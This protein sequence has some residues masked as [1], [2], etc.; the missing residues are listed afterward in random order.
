MKT[1]CVN[2]QRENQVLGTVAKITICQVF[3]G[4]LITPLHPLSS[5]ILEHCGAAWHYSGKKERLKD[6]QSSAL[7]SLPSPFS[8]SE[9]PSEYTALGY[10]P[11]FVCLREENII[12]EFL[13]ENL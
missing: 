13:M 5:F 8:K 11:I 12:F 4:A 6:R 7:S 10:Y 9:K 2:V 1:K 3:R